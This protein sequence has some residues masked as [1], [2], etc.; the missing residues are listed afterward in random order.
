[1]QKSMLKNILDE[2]LGWDC[3]SNNCHGDKRQD[4]AMFKKTEMTDVN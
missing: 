1:M 2:N 4:Q 3:V